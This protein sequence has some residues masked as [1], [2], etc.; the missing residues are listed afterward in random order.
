MGRLWPR[1]GHR[2]R[3][4]NRIV[5][6]YQDSARMNYSD[7]PKLFRPAL[8]SPGS[9]SKGVGYLRPSPR[10]SSKSER[11]IMFLPTSDKEQIA[12]FRGILVMAG[13]LIIAYALFGYLSDKIVVFAGKGRGAGSQYV[14]GEQVALAALGYV[15]FAV[16]AFI[17]AGTRFGRPASPVVRTSFRAIF[18]ILFCVAG[19]VL[20]GFRNPN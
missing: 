11:L 4:L 12:A 13:V 6:R 14:H 10:P 19:I 3:T 5:R 7:E 20:V 15:S 2:G 16:A 1:H 9:A 8:V 18:V 17:A